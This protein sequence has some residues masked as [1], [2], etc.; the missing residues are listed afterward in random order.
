MRRN[1]KIKLVAKGVV[2]ALAL[3]PFTGAAADTLQNDSGDQLN[4][5]GV[6]AGENALNGSGSQSSIVG[7]SANTGDGT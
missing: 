4:D 3:A 6:F 7:G 2:L 5:T 1:M